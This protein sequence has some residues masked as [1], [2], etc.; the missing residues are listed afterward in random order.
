MAAGWS[1]WGSNSETS[2]KG[3]GRTGWEG[4][5]LWDWARTMVWCRDGGLARP[6]GFEPGTHGLEGRCSIPLS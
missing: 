6:P 5:L 1:P 2:R 4:S 3:E